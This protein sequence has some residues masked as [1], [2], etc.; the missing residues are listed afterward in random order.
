MLYYYSGHGIA[1]V[2][3]IKTKDGQQFHDA[4]IIASSSN[5]FE[6]ILEIGRSEHEL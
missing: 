1:H 3:K 4:E 2:L 5:G 6:I